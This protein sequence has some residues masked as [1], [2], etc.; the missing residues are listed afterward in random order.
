MRSELGALRGRLPHCEEAAARAVESKPAT[1]DKNV[2]ARGLFWFAQKIVA[3]KIPAYVTSLHF[4]RGSDSTAL[5]TERGQSS[6]GMTTLNIVIILQRI[7]QAVFQ[8]DLFQAFLRHRLGNGEVCVF[9]N[10]AGQ[11]A[12]FVGLR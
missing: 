11:G 8:Q 10:R 4:D 7:H 12:V 2:F 9:V 5:L 1:Q 6:A 3:Q